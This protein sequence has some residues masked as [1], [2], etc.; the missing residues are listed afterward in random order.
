MLSYNSPPPATKREWTSGQRF[1]F[2]LGVRFLIFGVAAL[3]L[4]LFGLQFRKLEKLGDA[5]GIAGGVF[6]VGGALLML[7]A[8]LG[9][10][11]WLIAAVGIPALLLLAVGF[12]F[13]VGT[14]IRSRSA[15]PLA[16]RAA[17]TPPTIVIPQRP[18]SQ[19]P[20]YM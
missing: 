15:A 1:A 20:P 9:R 13:L 4:P 18:V 14:M 19:R 8:Y 11:A 12:F 7:G 10:R 2:K 17:P 16:I 6:A 3:I 5:A